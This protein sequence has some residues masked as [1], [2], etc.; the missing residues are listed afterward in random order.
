MRKIHAKAHSHTDIITIE[1]QRFCEIGEYCPK[2]ATFLGSTGSAIE[3]GP[4][5]TRSRGTAAPS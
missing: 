1:A 4:Q 2:L 3:V 5:T